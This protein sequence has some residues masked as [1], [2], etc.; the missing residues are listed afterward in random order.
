MVSTRR[1]GP[2]L[3]MVAALVL[4]GCTDGR[5][6]DPTEAASDPVAISTQAGQL[7]VDLESLFGEEAHLIAE[8]ARAKGAARAAAAKALDEASDDLVDTV[9]AAADA[10]N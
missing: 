9:I 5:D 8:T 2:T 1:G 10:D 4:G 7:R 6:G 3:L